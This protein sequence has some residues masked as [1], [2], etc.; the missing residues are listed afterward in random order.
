MYKV[1]GD[2]RD[3]FLQFEPIAPRKGSN[4][5]KRRFGLEQSALAFINQAMHISCRPGS[6]Q[7]NSCCERPENDMVAT[8]YKTIKKRFDRL[9]VGWQGGDGYSGSGLSCAFTSRN[10]H[11]ASLPCILEAVWETYTG[12]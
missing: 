7:P 12:K 5:R 10:P 1:A 6:A 9:R 8:D 3:D 4:G 2:V 11:S